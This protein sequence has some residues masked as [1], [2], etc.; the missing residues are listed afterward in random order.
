MNLKKFF[1][2]NPKCAIAFSGGVDSSYLL[3][4]AIKYGKNIKAYF[5]KTSF[6]PQ[7]EI[8]DAV[9]IAKLIGANLEIVQYN[10]LE[11]QKVCNN[12][13]D[14]C[15]DCKTTLFTN[16]IEIAKRDG[17]GLVLDGTN[18]SDDFSDR[19]GMRALAELNVRSPLRE[20]K[21]TKDKIRLLSRKAGLPTYNKP[22]YACLAT[23]VS[24][25][26][27]ITGDIL[28]KI[29]KAEMFMLRLGFSDFRVRYNNNIAKIQLKEKQFR[30][31]FKNKE[32]ISNEFC[33]Y[34]KEVL[35]DINAR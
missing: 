15:Y 4:E 9:E 8:D 11:N 34:F 6:Q 3:Y 26:T 20:S 33:K 12:N 18:A 19:P 35:L 22:A 23:R 24:T 25:G 16:I 13:F 29:E 5:I 30:L 14:R 28:S 10:I 21:L 2:E 31:F 32:A 1:N 7:F 27:K 17:F